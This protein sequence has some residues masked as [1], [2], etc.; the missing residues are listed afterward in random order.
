MTQDLELTLTFGAAA[1]SA[2]RVEGCRGAPSL[3]AARSQTSAES[4]PEKKLPQRLSDCGHTRLVFFP[5]RSKSSSASARVSLYRHIATLMG[6]PV[7]H[8][9]VR[10]NPRSESP[11]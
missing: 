2:E 7:M 3:S 4:E 5:F 9:A 1:S 6:D 8:E 10:W 11:S